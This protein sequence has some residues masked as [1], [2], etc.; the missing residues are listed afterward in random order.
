M[1]LFIGILFAPESPWY[2]VRKGR[3]EEAEKSIRRLTSKEF[4]KTKET[5]AM[6]VHTV[7]YENEIRTGSSYLDCFRGSNLRRTEICCMVFT[8]QG[9]TVHKEHFSTYEQTN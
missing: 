5:L 8:G 2:L 4:T 1:P 3:V 6:I 9:K 7:N